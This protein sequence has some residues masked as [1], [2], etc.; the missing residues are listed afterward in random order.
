MR[1]GIAWREHRS[2]L[3]ASPVRY[4]LTL[5]RPQ[6]LGRERAKTFGHIHNAPNPTAPTFAEIFEVLHGTAHLLFYSLDLK[7]GSSPLCRWVEARAGDK[8]MGPSNLFHLVIKGGD[9]TLVFADLIS[10]RAF[11]IY[12]PVRA[13]R[14]APYF[15]MIDGR[16]LPNPAF[17]Q[18]APLSYAGIR[19]RQDSRPL[20]TQFAENPEAFIWLDRPEIF[21]PEFELYPE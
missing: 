19:L 5:L 7:N 10:R 20:Y 21:P 11:G 8:I 3:S 6:P 18:V 12:D 1:N 2:A 16:W 9:T 13:T 17:R 4:E 14:G 15:E